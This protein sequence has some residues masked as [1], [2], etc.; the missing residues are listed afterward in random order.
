VTHERQRQRGWRLHE[1]G[2][3]ERRRTA[4]L[5]Y[6]ELWK[7]TQ[8][9]PWMAELDEAE[10]AELAHLERELL[11]VEDIVQFRALAKVRIMAEEAAHREAAESTPKPRKTWYEWAT[12]GSSTSGAAEEVP[13]AINFAE[14]AIELSDDQRATLGQHPLWP[15]HKHQRRAGGIM[16]SQLPGNQ[17]PL[18]HTHTVDEWPDHL[19]QRLH[20][21]TAVP[22]HHQTTFFLS[23]NRGFNP[24]GTGASVDHKVDAITQQGGHVLRGGGRNIAEWIGRR[25]RKWLS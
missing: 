13:F 14:G 15:R 7:R 21:N 2:F 9:K 12:G 6:T 4:R 18:E 3:F 16:P 5:R 10:R 24:D 1:P 11:A 23:H 20:R 17:R 25:R 19:C 22:Q 8:G